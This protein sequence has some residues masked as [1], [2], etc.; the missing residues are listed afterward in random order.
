MGESV[1]RR[2]TPPPQGSMRA[3]RHGRLVSRRAIWETPAHRQVG[4]AA[5]TWDCR[6]PSFG[7]QIAP[8]GVVARPVTRPSA[9]RA[10]E[11]G[12]P[13][14]VATKPRW[15]QNPLRS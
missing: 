9:T 2:G 8:M 1:R 7:Q 3:G 4:C 12:D 14:R 11:D 10:R 15:R 13:L 5:G 6:C